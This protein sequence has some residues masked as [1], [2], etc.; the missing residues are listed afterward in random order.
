M[1]SAEV[2]MNILRISLVSI[3]ALSAACGKSDSENFVDTYC[4]EVGKCCGQAGLPSDGKTCR[5][6]MALGAAGGSYSSSAGD[7]C[8]AEMR[9]Q[10]SAG[11]FCTGQSTST[12]SACDSVYGTG[13]KGTKKPGE[14]CDFDSDCAPSSDGAVRCADLYT[15]D[16]WINKCQVRMAGKAGDSPCVGTQEGDAFLGYQASGATDI[17]AR[18]YVCDTANDV[19]CEDGT[20]AAL[21]ALGASCLI[22]TDCVRSAYC[23]YPGDVCTT[24]VDVGG[25]CTG[26]AGSECVDSA[27]CDTSAK[28]CVSKLANGGDCTSSTVCQSGYCSNGTCQGSSNVAMTFLCGS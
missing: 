11:T 3:L 27:Y 9:A 25:A 28:K 23:S 16:T 21:A 20:C 17:V 6:W 10:V 26:I 12:P 24:K 2:L 8:L 22:S 15:G 19:S 4:S 14:T 1:A 13:S 5:Q 18:G 7:A